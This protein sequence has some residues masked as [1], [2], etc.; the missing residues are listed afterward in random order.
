VQTIET[1]FVAPKS[2]TPLPAA[3]QQYHLPPTAA[4]VENQGV[5]GAGM[6]MN[7]PAVNAGNVGGNM[8]HSPPTVPLRA[9]T[10]PPPLGSVGYIIP[11]NIE[12]NLIQPPA[13]TSTKVT[14]D[15]SKQGQLT[16]NPVSA[17]TETII[18]KKSVGFANGNSSNSGNPVTPLT[19]RP[20]KESIFHLEHSDTDKFI[21]DVPVSKNILDGAKFD[22]K[23]NTSSLKESKEKQTYLEG[24]GREFTHLRYTAITA[25]P[26]EFVA[27]NYS[28]RAK[29]LGRKIKI[30][31]V[32]TMYNE[33]DELFCKSYR[34]ILKN[35]AY[36]CSGK[37][38]WS[39]DS[40]KEIIVVIVSDGR[41]K[42][43]PN[44][45]TVLSVMGL[46]QEGL[47]KSSVNGKQVQGHMYEFTTQMSVDEQ[48][49]FRP[50]VYSGKDG[51]NMVP[52]QTI[53]LLKEKNQKKINSHRWFF[54]AI[55]DVSWSNI[56][57][58]Y[59]T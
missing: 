31:V 4:I 36:L 41:T 1:Y 24:G 51:L 9:Y 45:L 23:A 57:L 48:L 47:E 30:A 7:A 49:K 17:S 46:Y 21:L 25:D 34:A 33:P 35:I 59:K 22:G 32:V 44:V 40:W 6:I 26:D 5:T 55:C 43:N 50:G 14:E 58:P 53:F 37:A 38:L 27:Q 56:I 3:E 19:P 2:T 10:P 54:N 18:R 12:S 42:V 11:P 29:Q 15:V 16:K 28:T 52:V 8:Y 20:R 13:T 39:A